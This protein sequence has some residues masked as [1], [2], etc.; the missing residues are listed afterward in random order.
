MKNAITILVVVV[1]L[2]V[3]GYGIYALNTGTGSPAENATSTANGQP[4]NSLPDAAKGAP[5]T[6]TSTSNTSAN[7]EPSEMVIGKS[8]EGRDIV[9]YNFGTGDTQV[10]FIGGIHGGYSW[11]AADVAFKAIDYF[12]ENPSVIPANVKVTVIPNLN[13]DGLFDAVNKEGRFVK[14]DVTTSQTAL[15]ASR[16]NANKVD[17][18]RNFDCN[19]KATGTWQTKA[20][21]GGTAAFSEPE[22]L[23]IKNYVEAHNISAA[24]VWYSSAGG[25]YA[26]SCGSGIL[27]ETKTITDIYANASGY[28]AHQTFDAYTTT[29]DIVNWLAKANVPAISVLLKTHTSADWSEN[30]KGIDALL[31]HYAK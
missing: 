20:V 17:L 12:K 30:K 1:I 31:S 21:S 15:V 7:A 26:S 23:A 18:S 9:A 14:A 4:D 3:L 29:G 19:W 16:F 5:T 25:V 22:S 10:L 13:P 6:G 11:V 24:V 2:A 28:T 27:P 8:V